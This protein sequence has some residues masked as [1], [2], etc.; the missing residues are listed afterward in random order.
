MKKWIVG[1][2]AV[3]V[4][5]ACNHARNEPAPETEPG[6]S[7]YHSAAAAVDTA[8]NGPAAPDAFDVFVDRCRAG[9]VK[10]FSINRVEDEYRLT[11]GQFGKGIERSILLNNYPAV[12]GQ[13]FAFLMKK[14][15]RHMTVLW[16]ADVAGV[17][18]DTLITEKELEAFRHSK[19]K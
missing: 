3:V 16:E 5:S 13:I 10:Y 8:G 2:A 6:G 15:F 18:P 7:L 11:Y 14:T 1:L 19:P 4:V 9:K 12:R 17:E